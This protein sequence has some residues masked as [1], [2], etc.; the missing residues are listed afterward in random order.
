[1]AFYSDGEVNL[2]PAE[3]L[4]INILNA[5]VLMEDPDYYSAMTDA[6]HHGIDAIKVL[7]PYELSDSLAL[8]LS[9]DGSFKRIISDLKHCPPKARA[10]YKKART[11]SRM[12]VSEAYKQLRSVGAILNLEL[13]ENPDGYEPD[14][15]D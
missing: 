11:L 9:S 5:G 7:E 1:M 3:L 13:S 8:D 10:D 4:S 14:L 2:T 15:S 12:H 6:I